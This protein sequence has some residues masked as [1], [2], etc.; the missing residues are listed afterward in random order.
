LG[1]VF[2]QSDVL[3]EK[4]Y[5]AKETEKKFIWID[6][7]MS[8]LDPE[9]NVI[10]EIASIVTDGE[11]N[12]IAQGPEIVVSQ[13]ESVLLAMDKWCTSVHTKSGL[14]DKVKASATKLEEA[15]QQTLAFLRDHCNPSKSPLAG[16]SVWM[17][18][19]FIMKYMPRLYQ[20]LHY[21]TI[22]VSTIK[23]L[24]K[25]WYPQTEQL[26][27]KKQNAH[28][29]LDDIIESIEELKF[30]RNLLFKRGLDEA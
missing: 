29:A 15:E 1:V 5:M 27:F 17:D 10:L 24:A 25:N 23:E 18:R 22:D 8:G 9:A 19:V 26:K 16:N 14:Y 7:E 20:F 30:Y 4:E 21:R 12:I 28:R 3:K 6:L 13:P 11:L 2:L